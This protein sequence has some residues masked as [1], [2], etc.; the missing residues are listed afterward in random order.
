MCRSDL[1]TLT[2]VVAAECTEGQRTQFNTVVLV[3]FC[4]PCSVEHEAL[5]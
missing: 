5:I 4:Q 3:K 1:L 2:L